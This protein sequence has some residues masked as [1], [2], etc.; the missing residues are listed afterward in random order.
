MKPSK[1]PHKSPGISPFS[2]T[3]PEHSSTMKKIGDAPRVRYFARGHIFEASQ[4]ME[5]ADPAYTKGQGLVKLA[6]GSGWVIVPFDDEIIEQFEN[7]RSVEVGAN[8]RAA[9]EEIGNA[10]VPS[11][12]IISSHRLTP[13]ERAKQNETIRSK[14]DFIWLRVSSPHGVKVLLPPPHPE[15]NFRREE[16]DLLSIKHSN[17]S[18]D[19]ES[20]SIVSS[21]FFDAMWSKVTPTKHKERERVIEM[22]ARAVTI[23]KPHFPRHGNGALPSSPPLIPCGMVVPV[24][25]WEGY[26]EHPEESPKVRASWT[27]HYVI[28]YN[29]K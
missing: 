10:V 5:R 22:D 20:A 28:G 6:D 17:S 1:N 9:F 14:N 3:N 13:T 4:R 8:K 27:I 23:R 12:P 19:S 2:R 29:F 15:Q 21:S 24:E 18:K 7:F 26:H 16:R 11:K 25:R